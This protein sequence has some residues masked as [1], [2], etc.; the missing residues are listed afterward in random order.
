MK[1]ILATFIMLISPHTI[2]AQQNSNTPD[3]YETT[4]AIQYINSLAFTHPILK[5]AMGKCIENTDI[6]Q[7]KFIDEEINKAKSLMKKSERD[8]LILDLTVDKNQIPRIS[9]AACLARWWLMLDYYKL[10]GV[11]SNERISK[12]IAKEFIDDMT[13]N[14]FKFVAISLLFSTT[15]EFI[16]NGP[17]FMDEKMLSNLANQIFNGLILNDE[18]SRKLQAGSVRMT[19]QINQ[20]ARSKMSNSYNNH[21]EFAGQHINLPI[22]LLLIDSKKQWDIFVAS[23]LEVQMKRKLTANENLELYEQS[24]VVARN[25]GCRQ[26]KNIN[27]SIVSFCAR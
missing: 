24:M 2:F 4:L 21:L 12:A 27:E 23:S 10:P 20:I 3:F 7:F 5:S 9:R 17:W 15:Q 6:L 13:E 16:D 19:R 11:S 8:K 22:A 25:M 14:F 1:K 18:S 26:Q